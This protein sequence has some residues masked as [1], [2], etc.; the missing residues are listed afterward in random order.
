MCKLIK[1]LL[2]FAAFVYILTSPSGRT[3]FVAYGL[4]PLDNWDRGFE[5]RTRHGYMSAFFLCCALLCRYRS[6]DGPMFHNFRSQFCFGTG[7]RL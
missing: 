1:Q 5:S 4:G 3:V 7:Q 6:C 2:L